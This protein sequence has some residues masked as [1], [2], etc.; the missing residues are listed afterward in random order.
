[1]AAYDNVSL[2]SP[3]NI[4]T[5]GNFAQQLYSMLSALPQDYQKGQDFQYQ[6]RQRNLF[7]GGVPTTNGQQN[8]PM[9]YTAMLRQVLQAGGAPAI[10]AA[11][12]LLSAQ[13]GGEISNA[14]G[15]QP[16][17]A[18]IGPATSTHAGPANIT[19][20]FG[21]QGGQP[22]LSA[23]GSDSAG[24]ESVRSLTAGIAGSR[25]VPDTTMA[26]YARALGVDDP[27]A[28]L[29][30][31]QEARA[32]KIIGNN[33]KG[34]GGGIAGNTTKPVVSTGYEQDENNTNEATPVGSTG[35]AQVS[36]NPQGAGRGVGETFDSRFNAAQGGGQPGA[37]PT[38][39]GTEAE[40][41]KAI[42]EGQNLLKIAARVAGL[43]PKAAE[44]AKA[45]AEQ[46]FSRA[47]E[48]FESIGKYN[49]PTIKEKDVASGAEGRAK[50]TDADIKYYDSLHRGLA[51]SGM[52]AAQQKQNIDMLRQVAAAPSFSP[53]TG[54]DLWRAYQRAAAQFGINPTG[55][56]PREIFDQVAAR[57]LAD[58]FS[59]MKSLASETGEQGARV[60]KSML[61]IE[62]KANVTPEDSL[63][64]IK[65]KLDLVDK[66]GDLM[67]KWA[68]KADSYKLK[69][70]R[71]DAGFDKE[72]RADIAK[73]RVQNA[74]PTASG[75]TQTG[76]PAV[77][78]IEQG[79]RF[80]GG[81]HRDPKS[82]E[83]VTAGDRS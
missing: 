45:A 53:G 74:V 32:R 77:G 8:G 81:N 76:A 20:D 68:D 50:Q 37:R 46:R 15:G 54:T 72:L 23:T 67:M 26:N 22:K 1:M 43:N 10:G 5:A 69:H 42:D 71:L 80:K 55:A 3:P 33:L 27:D 62:E 11:T 57:I 58:Q 38:P 41:R 7:Q 35:G 51:G 6:Q 60:F 36:P 25:P 78:H 30:A 63:E 14:I 2:P 21:G 31:D 56:A 49:E 28:P 29:S 70:G 61:D 75:A 79:Y 47:K 19:G 18:N 73:A 34:G 65:A 83:K 40:A 17:P 24:A 9:D 48:I 52:I 16:Q 12:P 13:A 4:A 64:G 39:V 66:T 59:G 82:W 44:Q